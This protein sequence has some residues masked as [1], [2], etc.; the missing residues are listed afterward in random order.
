MDPD[1]QKYKQDCIANHMG[2]ADPSKTKIEQYSPKS[3][4]KSAK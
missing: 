1:F 4:K 2:Y 3:T